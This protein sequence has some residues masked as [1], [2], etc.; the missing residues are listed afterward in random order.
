MSLK[1]NITG[2][3]PVGIGVTVSCCYE[4]ERRDQNSNFSSFNHC[5]QRIKATIACH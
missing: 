1:E 2:K 4:K 3:V 5:I